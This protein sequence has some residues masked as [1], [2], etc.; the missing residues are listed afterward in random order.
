MTEKPKQILVYDTT[1]RDGCQ[2]EG[3]AMTLEDKLE[4]AER[5]DELGVHYIEGGYPLSNPK[6]EEFFRRAPEL[7]L[8]KAKICAFGSTRRADSAAGEDSGL[9]ALLEAETPVVTIVA[10][11]WDYH[12]T[13]V[14]RTSLEENLRM[15][16]DSVRLLK[17][18]GREVVFDAEHFFDGH[19]SNPDYALEVC[20]V[21]AEVGADCVV[22]CDTNGGALTDEVGR[23]TGRMVE[24]LECPV[25]IHCHN[26]SGL[27]VANTV[28]A[29][30][31]GAVHVQGTLNGLGERVGNADLCS[32]MAIINLKTPYR[33]VSDEELQKLTEA[34][35]FAYEAANLMYNPHQPFVGASAFAHKGGLHV[36]AMRKADAAYEH[37][38]PALV[39]NER[40]FL[41]SELSGHASMLAKVEKYNITHDRETVSELLNRLQTRENEG[42]QFEAAEASFELLARKVTGRFQPH[43]DVKSYHVSCIRQSDGQLVTDAT[44]KL[45][46]NGELMHTASEG[47]GPVN[48]LDGALRKALE[49]HYP[50]LKQMRLTDYKVRVINPKAATAARVRVVIQSTG[51]GR[52]WGTVGVSENIIDASWEALLDSV[53]YTLSMQE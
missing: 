13:E 37:I 40:R 7:K 43:F 45:A 4:V 51:G 53:E 29:V 9:R 20:R 38:D 30:Q 24:E 15:V 3:V 19:A 28:A 49:P 16:E 42:Y 33:C 2:A 47:D 52:V 12:V 10:K 11:A 8:R 1:L 14:L 25:G 27:G 39:G 36:D 32:I 34:S 46:V 5:L 41:L 18:A 26:D 21:A 6:D 44:V 48:A 22:L 17:E 23:L 35:R 31:N 50:A